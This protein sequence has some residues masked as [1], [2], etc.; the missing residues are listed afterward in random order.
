MVRARCRFGCV[1]AYDRRWALSQHATTSPTGSSSEEQEEIMNEGEFHGHLCTILT[2]LSN[3]QKIILTNVCRTQGLCWCH[4]AY[5][6]VYSR[7]YDA[8]SNRMFPPL[9]SVSLA[10]E[11]ICVR[12]TSGLEQ[13]WWNAWFVILR[14][15]FTSGNTKVKA[16]VTDE[17]DKY[18]SVVV[19]AFCMTPRKRFCTG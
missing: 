8:G 13:K 11:H 9:N 1:R 10:P 3:L 6:D 4:Q 19:S 7:R 14:A 15:L 17:G 18:S 12:S 5:V 16:I 2:V